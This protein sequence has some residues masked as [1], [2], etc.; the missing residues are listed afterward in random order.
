MV[1]GSLMGGGAERQM[2]N[3]ANY[4]AKRDIHVTLAT[5]SGPDIADF[6]RLDDKVR[7]VHLDVPKTGDRLFSALHASVRRVAKLRRLLLA[8]QPNAVLSFVT[9]SNVLTILARAG[10]ESR[11]VVSERVN[12]ALHSALPW[13]WKVLRR[14]VYRWTDEVV[15]QTRATA[16]WIG[17]NCRKTALVIPN[18][19][20]QLPHLSVERQPLILA[21]G[22]LVN[23]KGFDLLVRAFARIASDFRDWRVMF[24]G[25]G[26]ERSRL[27]RLC[28]DLEVEE[29]VIFAGQ[30]Q[31]VELWMARAG[32]VVQ[33]SRFEG[34]PNVVLESMAMGAAVISSDCASGPADLIEDGV[35]GRLVP[36]GDVE[37]LSRVMG[38]LMS[39]P[40]LRMRLGRE[41][42]NVRQRFNEEI[43]MAQWQACLFTGHQRIAR[44][45]PP[46]ESE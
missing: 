21:V 25:D 36:V 10:L 27:M 28:R 1:I 30:R 3:I 24:I 44:D 5:W 17:Q 14:V 16:G 12:P 43:V 13:K 2:V 33:P 18:G 34:F 31:D 37:A 23:Q 42:T 39:Q 4:W 29:R 6:Y 38:E 20:Y 9:E 7:R 45:C 46:L 41:A 40:D 26:D 35:N 19:L 32:I 11:L 8:S 22:R 15:A